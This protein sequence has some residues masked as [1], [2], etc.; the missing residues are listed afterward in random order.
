MFKRRQPA[1]APWVLLGAL[2]QGDSG[3]LNELFGELERHKSYVTDREGVV[4]HGCN[5]LL[6]AAHDEPPAS[7]A[8]VKRD[9][10]SARFHTGKCG[11]PEAYANCLLRPP[12]ADRLPR[13]FC[14]W[15]SQMFDGAPARHEAR[16]PFWERVAAYF[17]DW[18][19][20]HPYENGWVAWRYR[21]GH[22]LTYSTE[23]ELP[24]DFV[25][26]IAHSE[27]FA[28]YALQ[29][30]HRAAFTFVSLLDVCSSCTQILQWLRCYCDC[31][32]FALSKIK[33]TEIFSPMPR[34]IEDNRQWFCF[35]MN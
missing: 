19:D 13:N 31:D 15:L 3:Q 20:R 32:V 33:P 21:R 27:V 22:A 24:D 10:Q 34:A 30:T 16:F 35:R 8:T 1:D 14:V 25:M 7:F 23:K 2:A 29:L 26:H 5:M 4:P 11:P 18:L 17:Q 9:L 12:A 28:L 6:V